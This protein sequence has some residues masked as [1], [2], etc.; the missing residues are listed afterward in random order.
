[1]SPGGRNH[2]VGV[3][4]GKGERRL[5]EDVLPRLEGGHRGVAV[6]RGREADVHRVDRFV[7]DD[8]A[9]VCGP[10]RVQ[11]LGGGQDPRPGAP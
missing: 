8:F 2:H 9:V 11:F 3:A 10:C 6:H 5:D 7:V 1:M 4:R